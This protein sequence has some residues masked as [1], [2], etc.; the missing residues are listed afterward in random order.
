MLS[1]RLPTT[2]VL[3]AFFLFLSVSAFAPRPVWAQAGKVVSPGA[4]APDTNAKPVIPTGE[5]ALFNGRDFSGWYTFLPS[6]GV[7]NDPEHIFT[8]EPDGTVH[9][10]GKE[11]GY[12]A[13]VVPYANYHLSF[14]VKWGEKKWKPRDGSTTQRDSGCLVHVFDKDMVWPKS[15]E[16]QVQERDMGDIFLL[17]GV[18]AWANGKQQNGR[19]VRKMNNEKPHGAWNTVEIICKNDSVTNIVNGMVEN[20]AT[21]LRRKKDGTGGKLNFGRIALQSEGAEVFYRNIKI[22]PVE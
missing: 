11:F 2:A 13:T 10:S 16:C 18:S 1:F 12:F 5:T 9:V 6:K 7:N 17:G 22:R 19:V 15:F 4:T 20:E 21:R 3:G 14:E 8:V